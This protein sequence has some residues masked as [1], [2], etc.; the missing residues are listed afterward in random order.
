MRF[1]IHERTSHGRPQEMGMRCSYDHDEARSAQYGQ[2]YNWYAVDDE[3][4][5]CP[6]GLAS[7]E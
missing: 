1:P 5:L 4:G 2:L 3:R 7:P 6:S